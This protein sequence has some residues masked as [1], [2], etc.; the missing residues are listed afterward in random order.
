MVEPDSGNVCTTLGNR[1]RR[2]GGSTRGSGL[3]EDGVLEFDVLV[4]CGVI[5]RWRS[6]LGERLQRNERQGMSIY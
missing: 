5:Q 3:I 1:A 4:V 2:S 6:G